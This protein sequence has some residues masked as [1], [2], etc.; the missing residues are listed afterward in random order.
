MEPANRAPG[1]RRP[2][3]SAALGHRHR[4]A[5]VG[6]E[7]H[8]HGMVSPLS[9]NARDLERELEW[10]AEVLNARLQLYFGRE[11]PVKSVFE[12]A[13]PSLAGGTSP[14]AEFVR[15]QELTFAER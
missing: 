13:A 8:L 14:Y 11:C 7:T 6:A 12:I 1:R 9:D 15:Q 10:F 4:Q 5:P 3:R 2:R